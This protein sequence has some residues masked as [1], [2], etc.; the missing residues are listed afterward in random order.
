MASRGGRGVVSGFN[1][2]NVARFGGSGALMDVIG[3]NQLNLPAGTA[4]GPDGNLYVATLGDAV[5]WLRGATPTKGRRTTLP[6]D[7]AF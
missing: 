7:S 3:V 4:Y 6:D 5:T 1:S 2:G